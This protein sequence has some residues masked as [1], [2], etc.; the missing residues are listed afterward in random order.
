MNEIQKQAIEKI[1]KESAEFKGNRYGE[2]V[3]KPT[4]EALK[5]F[6]E[7]SEDFA[8]AVVNSD[9]TFSDCIGKVVE[10]ITNAISDIDVYKR[11]VQFYFP[12]AD[13]KFDM[14]IILPNDVNKPVETVE[15]S[16]K[17]TE[18]P[19]DQSENNR[20]ISLFDIM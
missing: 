7:S 8:Q 18:A 15:N 17:I 1:K 9:K 20:I 2:V 14:R 16:E 19:A 6:C 10:D 4:A 11:A 13:I 12:T 3:A 5:Q